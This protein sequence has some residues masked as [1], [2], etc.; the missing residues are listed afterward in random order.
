ME[1]SLVPALGELHRS[2]ERRAVRARVRRSP[3]EN[4]AAAPNEGA[5]DGERKL[6]AVTSSSYRQLPS[7]NG[8]FRSFAVCAVLFC[9]RKRRF[10]DCRSRPRYR[11][12]WTCHLRRT[13]LLL[14]LKKTQ[15]RG[16]YMGHKKQ[17][18][19]VNGSVVSL[20]VRRRAINDEW[21]EGFRLPWHN[22]TVVK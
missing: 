11:R 14:R 7:V 17:K 5:S 1:R 21:I 18:F 16:M 13:R 2:D 12:S 3:F 22:Y 19:V 15:T 9:S 6:P 8:S 10:C 4:A 20:Q